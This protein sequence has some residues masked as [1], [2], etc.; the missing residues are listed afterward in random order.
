MIGRVWPWWIT[1]P[2]YLIYITV[3]LAIEDLTAK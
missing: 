2:P 1:T 3:R